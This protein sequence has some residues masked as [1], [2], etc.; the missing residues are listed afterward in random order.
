MKKT[1]LSSY[2]STDKFAESTCEKV[3]HSLKFANI[4]VTSMTTT[5]KV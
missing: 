5:S 3:R 4:N 1:Y 2:T